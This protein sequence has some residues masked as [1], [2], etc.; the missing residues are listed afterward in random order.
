TR[1]TSSLS[2]ALAAFATAYNATIDAVD[3]QRGTTSSALA[4]QS[5]VG[6]LSQ[7]LSRLGTY[8][9]PDSQIGS[10]D[11][12]GLDLDKT[13]HLTFNPFRLLAADITNSSGV[14]A[15]FGAASGTGFL[16]L[17]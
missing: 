15:F 5:L 8:S 2:D 4:G 7:V 6:N 17:A 14:T 1:T 13:G 9:S 12:V 16:R 11:S 10:M 3:S